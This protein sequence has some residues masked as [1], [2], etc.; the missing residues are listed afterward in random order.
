MDPSNKIDDLMLIFEELEGEK[1]VVF[2]QSKQL[3]NLAAARL[4]RYNQ[5]ARRA[6]TEL[7]NYARIT[8][9]ES[10]AVRQANMDEF[11]SA[12]TVNIVLAT[13]AAGGTGITLTASNVMVRM[14]RDW[15]SVNNAQ[16]EDRIHR[17]G[18]EIHREVRIIDQITPDTIEE[19]QLDILAGKYGNLQEILRDKKTMAKLLAGKLKKVN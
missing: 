2:A 16:A 17:I 13:T 11:Q 4:D 19:T 15:S 9:D 1:V 18:S 7:L 6:N 12:R 10:E 14:Q 5:A 3:I 8:G